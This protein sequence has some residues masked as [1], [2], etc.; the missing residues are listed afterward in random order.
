MVRNVKLLE[1]NIAY[2]KKEWSKACKLALRLCLT[3]KTPASATSS[4]WSA[5][6]T[7]RSWKTPKY[8]PSTAQVDAL[9]KVLGNEEY[10][11][12]ELMK[13]LDLTHRRNFT[14]F[15]INPAIEAG[16]IEPIYPNQPRHPKQKY[17]RKN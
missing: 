5:P 10:S 13:L 11:A 14:K 15:Y 7:P 3:G 4:S 17:R 9:L 8:R 6:S 1:F 2:V 16:V 12:I